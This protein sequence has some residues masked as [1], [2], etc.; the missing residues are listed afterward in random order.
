MSHTLIR[1]G[2]FKGNGNE[3]S[4]QSSL[5]GGE[6]MGSVRYSTWNWGILGEG[7]W[8]REYTWLSLES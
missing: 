1:S 2:R 3:K 4:F 6:H 7:D 8:F 5:L